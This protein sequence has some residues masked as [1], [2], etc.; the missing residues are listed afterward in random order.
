MKKKN[1]IIIAL[2]LLFFLLVGGSMNTLVINSNNGRMPLLTKVGVEN[3]LTHFQYQNKEEIN[4]PSLAD[5]YRLN[6]FKKSSVYSIGDVFVLIAYVLSC[7]LI[8]DLLYNAVFKTKNDKNN[9]RH[10]QKK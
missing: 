6:P 1:V 7:Y 8:I 2:L 9:I 3:P 10:R 4:Y 5:N